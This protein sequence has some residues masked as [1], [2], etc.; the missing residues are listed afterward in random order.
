MNRP[1]K[2]AELDTCPQCGSSILI[3]NWDDL[4]A[5]EVTPYRVDPTAL[6]TEDETVCIII[7]RPTYLL[8]ENMARNWSLSR[9]G[10]HEMSYP[11]SP[12][13]IAVLPHH[14][15]G[16]RYPNELTK[17]PRFVGV[18]DLTPQF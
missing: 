7:G 13:L 15:C 9:R 10:P 4:Q 8:E 11:V 14:K 1:T 5:I 17:P 12:R 18:A 6:T 3:T 16:A 2:R